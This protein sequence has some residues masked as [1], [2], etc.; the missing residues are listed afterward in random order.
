MLVTNV[1]LSIP[2]KTIFILEDEGLI[3]MMLEDLA[4]ELGATEVLSFR[5]AKS[6]AE[7]ARTARIDCA[8]LDV[9]LHGRENYDVAA[10]F[11]DR[12]IP[13]VFSTG[14][15]LGTTKGRYSMVP[16]VSK[17]FSDADLRAGIELALFRQGTM[18]PS[19]ASS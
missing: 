19:L 8:I 5:D 11:Q 12:G 4:R 16:I 10:I 9:H 15:T 2:L 18:Q 1:P 17:P 7:A 13:M 3:A 6:G 14:G